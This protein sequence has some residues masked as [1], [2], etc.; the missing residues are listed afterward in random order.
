[1]SE[2][3][4]LEIAGD[5]SEIIEIEG[6]GGEVVEI[7]AGGDGI[8]EINESVTGVSPLRQII[9]G[10]GLSGGGALSADVTIDLE[11]TA[12]VAGSYT[13]MNA[14]VDAQG[15][16]TAAANGSAGGVTSIFGRTGVVTAQSGDYT[17]AQ[18]GADPAGTAAA[19]IVAHLAA[20][21]PHPQY[22]T[23]AEA[24]ALYAAISHSH[25]AATQLLAGFMS[26][27]DK[28]KLDNLT[29]GA[30]L[31][32]RPGGVSGAGVVATWA[33]VDAFAAAQE[34]P[35]TLIPDPTII[36]DYCEVPSSADTNL[37]N[38]CTIQTYP[39]ANFGLK[40]KDG[41]KLRNPRMGLGGSIV[42]EAITTAGV[43]LDI[44]GATV[45]LRE[46]GFITNILGVSLVACIDVLVG[47]VIIASL[48]AGA[49]LT[50]AP[51]VPMINFAVQGGFY[52]LAQIV[53]SRGVPSVY[54]DNSLIADATS[55]LFAIGDTTARLGPQTLF[56]G[57]ILNS[58]I[59]ASDNLSWSTCTSGTRPNYA[60]Q[61]H[62][63]FETDTKQQ[64]VFDGAGW[65]AHDEQS[66]LTY[67]EGG[68]PARATVT[69]WAEV[70]AF[71]NAQMKPWKLII[72]SSIA[73]C[74]APTGSTVDMR[75]L[76]TMVPVTAYTSFLSED[77]S[78]IENLAGIDEQ[79]YWQLDAITGPVARFTTTAAFKVSGIS[80]I[81]QS[82][83]SLV[84]SLEWT[85]Q[86]ATI[87]IENGSYVYSLGFPKIFSLEAPNADHYFFFKDCANAPLPDN[88]IDADPSG[89][90]S[91]V[92]DGSY[93]FGSQTGV[94]VGKLNNYPYDKAKYVGYTPASP[95]HWTGAPK[96][97]QEAIDRIA[98]QVS[99]GGGTPIP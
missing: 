77:G 8:V 74:K 9:A 44:N 63:V 21:D 40:V 31:I 46:G 34:T 70:I 15:R 33:E 6:E 22:L 4:I 59:G 2:F 62:T 30:Q 42:C 68:T 99:A 82:A 49:I 38:I 56:L 92:H 79:M 80:G 26:T 58:Q 88:S 84:K 65:T 71:A 7:E 81:E 16:I 93:A 43:I 72:D 17:P 12:V 75:C 11:N 36:A 41:G 35:W 47:N 60:L 85:T 54:G 25:P 29:A 64:V 24:D 57:T 1:M 69:T 61:G 39:G 19:A 91:S 51:G 73:Q 89:Y 83:S 28:T 96:T 27:A 87:Q 53:N 86:Y 20:G 5:N 55:T 50:E 90:V 97:V 66:R 32:F 95:S 76:C 13:N 52:I 14:T 94:D 37:K 3:E 67:K 48:S 18:V 78:M 23:P 98:A 45:D 10:V